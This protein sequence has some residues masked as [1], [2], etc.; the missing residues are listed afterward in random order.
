MVPEIREHL[1]NAAGIYRRAG[2][3]KPSSKVV[4][5]GPGARSVHTLA[6]K[7]RQWRRWVTGSRRSPRQARGLSSRN[8]LDN[9]QDIARS[10]RRH[11]MRCRIALHRFASATLRSRVRE[12]HC[13]LSRWMTTTLISEL[14]LGCSSSKAR[15]KPSKHSPKLAVEETPADMRKAKPAPEPCRPEKSK[16]QRPQAPSRWK[17]AASS[18]SSWRRPTR[19][20]NAAIPC[21]TPGATTCPTPEAGAEPAA[22][23]PHLQGRRPHGRPGR[24]GQR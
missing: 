6:G 10:P 8:R 14:E 17:K 12:H 7:L 20:W 1:D 9:G 18:P 5:Q 16:K 19:F 11:W 2:G 23:N 21:S 22:R 3:R 24:P 15:P 13:L 4:S